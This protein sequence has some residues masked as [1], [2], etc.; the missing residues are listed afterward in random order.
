MKKRRKFPRPKTSNEK[1]EFSEINK[2]VNKKQ[3]AG[4]MRVLFVFCII[5]SLESYILLFCHIIIT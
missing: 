4:N 1:V 3:R 2:A 5:I